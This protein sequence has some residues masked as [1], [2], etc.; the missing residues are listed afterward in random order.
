M[1]GLPNSSYAID[2][3]GDDPTGINDISVSNKA[4]KVTMSYEHNSLVIRSSQSLPAAN[5]YIYNVTGQL[6]NQQTITLP[7]G[8]Y[9][10][11]Y[12]TL[13]PGCYIARLSDRHGHTAICKFFKK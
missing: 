1:V 12:D 11:T 13:S 9:E 5:L 3:T 8:Y 7:N 4:E 2:L 6:L 10:Q